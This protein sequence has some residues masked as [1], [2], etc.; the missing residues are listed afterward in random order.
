MWLSA[1][2]VREVAVASSGSAR[3]SVSSPR[4]RSTEPTANAAAISAMI[5]NVAA[6]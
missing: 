4:S 5:P 3:P 2:R 1:Q 6:R